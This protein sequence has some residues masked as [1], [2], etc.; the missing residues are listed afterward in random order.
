M[1]GLQINF[2]PGFF[3]TEADILKSVNL[4]RAY[5]RMDSHHIQ[6][7]VVDAETLKD[8]QKNPENYR[9]LTPS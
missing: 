5:F 3:N 7:N 1:P 9:N 6:F 2:T 4:I 8:A